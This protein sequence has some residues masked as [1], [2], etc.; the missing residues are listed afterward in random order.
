MKS[1]QANSFQ[2]IEEAVAGAFDGLFM[3]HLAPGAPYDE[4]ST[5]AHPAWCLDSGERRSDTRR[6]A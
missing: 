1:D 6:G 4:L 5:D 2:H 3:E